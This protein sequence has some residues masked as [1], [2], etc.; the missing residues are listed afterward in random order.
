MSAGQL[1]GYWRRRSATVAREHAL[2]PPGIQVPRVA[3]RLIADHVAVRRY[4]H[5]PDAVRRLWPVG[6]PCSKVMH[7]ACRHV[8]RGA[9]HNDAYPRAWTLPT[10][11]MLG[12]NASGWI[13][14]RRWENPGNMLH[15]WA[16]R[17]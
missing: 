6:V 4:R 5:Q 14:A 12:P 13:H 15:I 2:A 16:A 1:L 8:P 11:W 10:P 7:D 3:W 9:G 17:A